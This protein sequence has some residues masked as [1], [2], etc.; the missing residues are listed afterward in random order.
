MLE[1]ISHTGEVRYHPV[2]YCIPIAVNS[3]YPHII[4]NYKALSIQTEP[5]EKKI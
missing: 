1:N 2:P 4:V 5:V 3:R